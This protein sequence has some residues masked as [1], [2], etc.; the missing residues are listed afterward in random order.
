MFRDRRA[1]WLGT[2]GG[3]ALSAYGLMPARSARRRDDAT[4]PKWN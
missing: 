2:G 3:S 4:S 1:F